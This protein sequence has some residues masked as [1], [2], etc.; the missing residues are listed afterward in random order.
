MFLNFMLVF[1][2][3]YDYNVAISCVYT[4]IFTLFFASFQKDLVIFYAVVN[5]VI[6]IDFWSLQ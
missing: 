6:G 2:F 1:C 3:F 4:C 5:A